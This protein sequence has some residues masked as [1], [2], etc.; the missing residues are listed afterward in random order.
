MLTSGHADRQASIRFNLITSFILAIC[1]KHGGKFNLV[2][3][4]VSPNWA[5]FGTKSSQDDQFE[6]SSINWK[7]V[8]MY[9]SH[10]H[11]VEHFSRGHILKTSVQFL[12]IS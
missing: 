2:I 9:G 7:V 11:C 12:D 3:T 4:H 5:H 8:T 6:F 10:A 1:F